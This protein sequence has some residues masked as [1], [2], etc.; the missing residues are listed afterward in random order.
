MTD[1]RYG[2][3][4]NDPDANG[5]EYWNDPR[6]WENAGAQI[7]YRIV[8]TGSFTDFDAGNTTQVGQLTA[9]GGTGSDLNNPAP[10]ASNVDQQIDQLIEDD[11]L[12]GIGVGRDTNRRSNGGGSQNAEIQYTPG[13]SDGDQM[14]IDLNHSATAATIGTSLFYSQ[15]S[16]PW[17]LD[18]PTSEQLEYQ[19]LREVT[20][21]TDTTIDING[22]HYE[23]IDVDHTQPATNT[24]RWSDSMA[25]LNP[26]Q[27]E[28]TAGSGDVPFDA[29]L[30]SGADYVH[31]AP[32]GYSP[33]SDVSDY[34][35]SYVDFTE[36]VGP[37]EEPFTCFGG[38]NDPT[39]TSMW[40]DAEFAYRI[41][42]SDNSDLTPVNTSNSGEVAIINPIQDG[43]DLGAVG[44][45]PA[46]ATGLGVG[47]PEG[48]NSN[49]PV[50]RNPEIQGSEY[51]QIER[52]DALEIDFN[53]QTQSARIGLS[54]FYANER[55]NKPGG[56]WERRPEQMRVQLFNDDTALG[57]PILVRAHGTGAY[58]GGNP[59][60]PGNYTFRV[61]SD[62]AFN[63]IRFLGANYGNNP[64]Q[65]DYVPAARPSDV[66]DYLVRE[67]CLQDS[68]TGR[69]F[70]YNV[71][72]QT[73]DYILDF[74]Q[75]NNAIVIHKSGFGLDLISDFN[76]IQGYASLGSSPVSD[77]FN[78]NTSSGKLFI[79]ADGP[80]GAAPTVLT[81]LLGTP[82][83]DQLF[84]VE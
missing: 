76:S 52:G 79:N 41:L 77:Y 82:Q 73:G 5:P 35:F 32:V 62:Q 9:L 64:S 11:L 33:I 70:H 6:N 83:L 16:V 67:I 27:D 20:Q 42:G 56:G 43:T 28:F 36:Y 68:L 81:T 78:Y 7:A 61:S 30:L 25:H 84:F 69:D 75:N 46:A 60:N 51:D 37:Q 55:I 1:I 18:G 71:P 38:T 72:E 29:I 48:S 2:F 47:L 23:P 19:L 49:G 57:D 26:G 4:P 17:K 24:G 53:M 22:R 3:N 50:R 39:N 54:V 59:G 74:N 34:L 13:M 8:G 44:N 66:S 58:R 65:P 15:E 31:P 63:T 21:N 14:L 80:G 10:G 12:S 40:R 45:L